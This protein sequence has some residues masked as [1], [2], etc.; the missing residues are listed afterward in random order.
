MKETRNP[1]RL[2]RSE[3]IETDNAFLNLFEPGI[4]DI[5]SAEEWCEKVHPLRSAAGGGKTSLLRLFTPSVLHTLHARRTEDTLKPLHQ[6]ISELGAINENG[7]CLLGVVLLCGQNYANLHDLDLDQARRNR[8]FFSLLNA[9]VVLAT[10]RGAMAIRQLEYPRDLD[11]LT[12]TCPTMPEQLPGLSMPCNGRQLFAWAA[13]VEDQICNAL[14]SFGP[15]ESGALPGHDTL[16][17]LWLLRPDALRIDGTPIVTRTLLMMDDIH[18]LTADQRRTLIETVIELRSP[19]GVWIAERFEALSTE[20]MLAS[21]SEEGRDHERPIEIEQYWRKYFA[22]FEKYCIRI[23]DRRVAIADSPDLKTFGTCIAGTLDGPEWTKRFTDACAVIEARIHSSAVGSKKYDAWISGVKLQE[24]TPQER[25]IAWRSL[26][27]LIARDRSRKQKSLLFDDEPIS[28]DERQEQSDSSLNHA[29][30]LFLAR[31]FDIPYYYG[32]DRLSRLAS[33]NIQQFLGI[34]GDVFAESLA[35][36][37]KDGPTMLRPQRQH[38]LMKEAAKAW[39]E[40]IPQRVMHGHEVRRFLEGIGEFSRWYT[41]GPTAK[42]DPGVS[43]TAIRMSERANLMDPEYLKRNPE[44]ARLA[45]IIASALAHNLL[46]ADLD[47]N[48][49]NE[50]WLVLNLNRLLCVHFDLPLGYGQY[51]ER[52]LKTLCQW[53][54][55]RFSPPADQEALL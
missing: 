21:G 42:N 48:C 6:K 3:S 4:L 2:R 19:V 33:L 53:I 47:Y 5:L 11:R 46:V 22:R 27:I 26:E 51:K 23:A 8:L 45:R 28:E 38:E 15:L 34:A 55:K 54:D 24:G 32:S 31:E 1:F 44:H 25:A 39:W 52:P 20:E 29:A 43:G 30:E 7:P 50:K 12:V 35:A 18:K 9:R 36:T 16:M 40:S 17:S 10:L 49:K 37:L 41:F 14:D 13:S